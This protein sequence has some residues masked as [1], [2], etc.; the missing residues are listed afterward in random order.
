MSRDQPHIR[1][2]GGALGVEVPAALDQHDQDVL[3][4][5]LPVGAGETQSPHT[6]RGFLPCGS[7]RDLERFGVPIGRQVAA[8]FLCC[9]HDVPCLCVFIAMAG[10]QHGQGIGI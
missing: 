7:Q 6:A 1:G 8:V 5:I 2:P 3:L 4:Q 9:L 10:T